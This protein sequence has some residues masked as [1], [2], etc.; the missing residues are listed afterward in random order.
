METLDQLL[1]VVFSAFVRPVAQI[2]SN[3][4]PVAQKM[5]SKMKNDFI[6]E[7]NHQK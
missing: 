1:P 3:V 2:P 4:R 7:K 5:T 6:F